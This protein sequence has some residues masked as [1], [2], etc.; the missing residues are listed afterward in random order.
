MKHCRILL[1]V[2]ISF[3][4]LLVTAWT[5]LLADETADF[6]RQNCFSCHTIGGGRLTGPDLKDV[7]LRAKPD[8]LVRYLLDPKAMIDSGDP[9]AAK[10]L[11]EARGVVMP[12]VAGINKD[13]AA[14]LLAL[15]DA[16]SKLEK[17]QFQGMMIS[18]APFTQKEID[19]GRD[20]FLGRKPLANGGPICISCHSIKGIN[21]MGGGKLGPDLSRVFERLDGR[22]ALGAWLMS[23][24]TA[25]MGPLFKNTT[26]KMEEIIPLIALFES[27]AKAG[28]EDDGGSSL[29]F[30]F[31]GL[32]CAGIVMGFIAS[33]WQD[34]HR[35]VRRPMVNGG[36]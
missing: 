14:A 32:I 30:L 15:I 31:A 2:G 5:P 29:T 22:K 8:W 27:S 16:E 10:L 26:L 35:A 18:L 21:Y 9:Y 1:W 36:A 6:F 33:Y 28:G 4:F 13:K 34:R 25:N 3:G 7:A 20:I 24:A 12:T 11:Q 19:L 17:S 23:P